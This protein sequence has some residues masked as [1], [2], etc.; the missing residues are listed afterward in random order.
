MIEICRIDGAR[1]RQRPTNTLAVDRLIT[2]YQSCLLEQK[3]HSLVPQHWG[4]DM[5]KDVP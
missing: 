2:P 1:K 4:L 3:S 5:A